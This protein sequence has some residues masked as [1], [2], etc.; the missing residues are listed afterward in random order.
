MGPRVKPV[1]SPT[2][3]APLDPPD[4]S[5]VGLD[6]TAGPLEVRQ[7]EFSWL[8]EFADRK[9]ENEFRNSE[10]HG[11]FCALT[12]VLCAVDGLLFFGSFIA[13][14][15]VE[16]GEL[17][18]F[19]LT[20]LILFLAEMMVAV[21]TLAALHRRVPLIFSELALC[22]VL[23]SIPAFSTFFTIDEG[24]AP[25]AV[26]FDAPQWFPSSHAAVTLI[27]LSRFM[28]VG[29]FFPIRPVLY[30]AILGLSFCAFVFGDL[31]VSE[32]DTKDAIV[33][34]LAALVMKVF[35]VAVNVQL[36]LI[37]RGKY[38]FYRETRLA[39]AERERLVRH[40]TESALKLKLA[41]DERRARSRL[42]RMVM[43]DLR[44]PLLSVSNVAALLAAMP[45]TTPLSDEVAS[46]CITSLSTCSSLTQQIL[47]DML[48]SARPAVHCVRLAFD[49]FLFYFSTPTVSVGGR[50][51]VHLRGAPP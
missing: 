33:L 49:Y 22:A 43:H 4:S 40:E 44:S 50:T 1:E 30:S 21:V 47:S 31:L 7:T 42:I 14:I 23:V 45:S 12:L 37:Y 5:R 11:L 17:S 8:G 24:H 36:S 13:D 26:H 29:L 34:V 32:I 35:L 38:W 27:L 28:F 46:K 10:V 20:A 51:A 19:G 15:A 3:D 6:E 25:P 48:V 16:A 18:G 41:A 9:L 39:V 2:D